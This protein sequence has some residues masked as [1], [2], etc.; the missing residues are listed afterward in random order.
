MDYVANNE[1]P[2]TLHTM[3][4]ALGVFTVEASA[5]AG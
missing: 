1:K 3:F 5:A 4:E 2:W